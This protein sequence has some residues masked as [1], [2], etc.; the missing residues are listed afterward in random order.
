MH[1][2][3]CHFWK[4]N[5]DFEPHKRT[6]VTVLHHDIKTYMQVGSNPQKMPQDTPGVLRELMTQVSW[7]DDKLWFTLLHV[8]KP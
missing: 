8:G 1:V 7:H 3:H 5:T 6:Y 4:R 2:Q